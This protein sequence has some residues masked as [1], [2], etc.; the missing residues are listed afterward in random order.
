MIVFNEQL[1]GVLAASGAGKAKNMVVAREKEVE[2]HGARL[3]QEFVREHLDGPQVGTVVLGQRTTKPVRATIAT[4]EER[5][6]EWEANRERYQRIP[7][8]ELDKLAVVVS[9][10]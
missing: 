8:A 3:F 7:D 1:Y 2:Y 6:L 9:R 4:L 10:I 5:L